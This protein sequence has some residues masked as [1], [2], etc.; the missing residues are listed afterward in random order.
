M[1]RQPGDAVRAVLE[2][3]DE[4]WRGLQAAIDGIPDERMV[5]PGVSGDWSVKDLLGHVAV[6]DRYVVAAVRRFLAGAATGEV[7]WQRMNEREAAARADRSVAEQRE[8]MERAHAAMVA[9]VGALGPAEFRT[10]N[11]RP[12]I[13]VD[14]YEHYDEHAADIRAWRERTGV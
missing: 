5:E 1:D 12:R 13:R 11:V 6:W 14:T 10:K 3:I 9:F 4:R 2:R 8:E 7:D